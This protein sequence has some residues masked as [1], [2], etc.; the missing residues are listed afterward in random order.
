MT[1]RRIETSR[2]R[3]MATESQQAAQGVEAT[4]GL[5]APYPLL[6]WSLL[7]IVVVVFA[8]SLH[9]AFIANINWDEFYVLSFVHLYR[10]GALSLSLQTFHVHLFAWLP[11]VSSN[12]IDQI[13]A[14]RVVLWLLSVGSGV[15]I[16]NIARSFCSRDGAL[17]SVLF[18]FGFSSVVDHGLSFRYDP[19]CAFLFLAALYLLVGAGRTRSRLALSAVCM[20]VALLVS[21]KS[22][23]FFG[24]IG[25]VFLAFLLFEREKRAVLIDAA[26]Y[27]AVLAGSLFLLY[28][29]HTHALGDDNLEDATQKLTSAGTKVLFSGPF[30][31]NLSS[32]VNAVTQNGPVWVFVLLGLAKAAYD[33]I[34]GAGR[35]RALILLSFAVPLLSLFLYSETYAYFFVFLMPAAVVLGGTFADLLIER[36]RASRSKALA[37]VLAGTVLMIVG[38]VVGDTLKRLPDQT[39]AQVEV[40]ALVHRLFPDPVPYID[41]NSMIASYPKV[42][43][44]MS[45]WGM[46]I[47]RRDKAAGFEDLIRREQPRFLINNT[48]RLGLSAPADDGG[49]QCDSTLFEDDI[50]ALRDN[51][52]H[53]WGALYVAGKSFRQLVPS[54][55]QSFETLTAGR[56]TIEASGRVAIDDEI[57]RPG[58]VVYLAQAPH[59]IRAIDTATD[60]VLRL[61]EN[62]FKPDRA[63]SSQPIYHPL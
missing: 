57:Y 38:T 13:V 18:Y 7:A 46:E 63:P 43:F 20:A 34:T 36:V 59:T 32:I 47:Y 6:R 40:V 23:L 5:S 41:R 26:L 53:H 42:G 50:E 9:R 10:N 33:L 54:E 22:V 44:F 11:L 24:T 4:K 30:L 8:L 52:V 48:C 49:S 37:A 25:T 61:G 14:A 15:L 39:V 56:Y 1:A 28:Q 45:R 60:V 35:K 31:Q 51:F 58:D 21:I 3:P 62:P 2:R 17:F 16:Y 29:L 19:I 27:A 12:E 55:S